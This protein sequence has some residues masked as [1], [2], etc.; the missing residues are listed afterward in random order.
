MMSA[1]AWE[2]VRCR[3]SR[4]CRSGSAAMLSLAPSSRVRMP[5]AWALVRSPSMRMSP[6]LNGEAT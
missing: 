6:S 1:L 3:C 2:T 4:R 5:S